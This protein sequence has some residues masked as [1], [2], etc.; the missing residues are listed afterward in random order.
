MS[1]RTYYRRI[2]AQPPGPLNAKPSRITIAFVPV[3]EKTWNVGFAICSSGDIFVK[4]IGRSIAL[5]RAV[6]PWTDISTTLSNEQLEQL[7]K[8]FFNAPNAGLMSPSSILRHFG[9]HLPKYAGS[10]NKQMT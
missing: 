2:T 10:P 4:A 7:E 8:S 5:G 9:V 3:S 6:S 1:R